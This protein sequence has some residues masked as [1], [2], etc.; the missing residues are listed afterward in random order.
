MKENEKLAKNDKNMTEPAQ[1]KNDTFQQKINEKV[2]EIKNVS[3][4]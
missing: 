2:S 4:S 1:A 3:K